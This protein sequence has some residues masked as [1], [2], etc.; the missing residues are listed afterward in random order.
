MQTPNHFSH[1]TQQLTDAFRIFN[2]LSEH[3]TAS[4]QGLEI[5]VGKLNEEL[6]AVR[7]E[8]LKTLVEKEKIA[9][10]L[11]HLLAALPA[12]VIVVGADGKVVDCNATSISFLGK[13]LLGELWTDIMQSRLLPVLDNP[14]ERLLLTGV[15]VSVT[16]NLLAPDSGQIVVLSDV[17]EMRELQDV[18]NQQKHLSAMGE[19][20]ASMAHQVR[21]PLSTAILYASHLTRPGLSEEKLHRFSTKIQERLHYLETQVNDML[22]FAKEGRLEMATFYLNELIGHLQETMQDRVEA[23]QLRFTIEN[24]VADTLLTGNEPALSGALMNLLNNA[25]EASAERAEILLTIAKTQQQ[26]L[27]LLVQDQG[28]GMSEEV[29]ARIFEPFFTTKS[30]GTGLGLAVVD[31]VIRAHGGRVSC[32]SKP[33]VGTVFSVLLPL[34]SG[35]ETVLSGGFSGRH[36]NQEERDYETL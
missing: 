9:T 16:Q 30:S 25:I 26:E 11:Q 7:S 33:S 27:Q 12:G 22:I 15:R 10:R 20:V 34:N 4:Y 31:S 8:R 14:H 5:Q 29:R 1:K 36:M 19:M 13:P 17:S 23:K 6:A 24:S 21:T 28:V 35:A 3:L 18:V 32:E 2:E